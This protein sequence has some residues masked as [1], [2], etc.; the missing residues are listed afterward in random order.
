MRRRGTARSTAGEVPHVVE[1]KCVFSRIHYCR[2]GK[3]KNNS[4]PLP[5]PRRAVAGRAMSDTLGPDDWLDSSFVHDDDARQ[6]PPLSELPS[7]PP[8]GAATERVTIARG[9]HRKDVGALC[10]IPPLVLG[11]PKNSSKISTAVKSNSFPT[12]L[13]PF[14][15]APRVLDD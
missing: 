12:I 13:G 1:N 10:G 9:S 7:A 14:V 11:Y 4:V 6:P 2:I 15:F 8:P 5:L 3:W